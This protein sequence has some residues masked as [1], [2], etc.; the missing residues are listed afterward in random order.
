M[1]PNMLKAISPHHHS[2]PQPHSPHRSLPGAQAGFSA[3][4]LPEGCVED[5]GDAVLPLQGQ[6]DDPAKRHLFNR[7]EKWDEEWFPKHRPLVFAKQLESPCLAA[8][9]RVWLMKRCQNDNPCYQQRVDR[10]FLFLGKLR[11]G[12]KHEKK[13]RKQKGNKEKGEYLKR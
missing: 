3:A 10:I 6:C 7:G 12:G 2:P 11:G 8:E 9:Q 5:R 13:I 1:A 4:V